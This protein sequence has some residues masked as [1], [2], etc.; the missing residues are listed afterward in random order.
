MDQVAFCHIFIADLGAFFRH[1]SLV[2]IGSGEGTASEEQET[3][4][5]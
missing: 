5:N 2:Q 3:K 4:T 1:Q